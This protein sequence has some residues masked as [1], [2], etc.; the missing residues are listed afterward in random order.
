LAEE[1]RLEEDVD[2]AINLYEK[3][4][5]LYENLPYGITYQDDLF[6]ELA[7]SLQK[8]IDNQENLSDQ[9]SPKIL[10]EKVNYLMKA[11]NIN[12]ELQDY[13]RMLAINEKIWT[14]Y[15][16]ENND[17]F[18]QWMERFKL[19]VSLALK[20]GDILEIEE[21]FKSVV[22]DYDP[23]FSP[24]DE[25]GEDQKYAD[26]YNILPSSELSQFYQ[27]I[28]TFLNSKGLNE[29]K[30]K[31]QEGLKRYAKRMKDNKLLKN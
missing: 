15:S 19:S 25:L 26:V 2:K 11:Y 4:I 22:P 3:A 31:I 24:E 10:I 21:L 5:N 20:T 28:I 16:K 9:E 6:E 1:A 12:E 8:K 18:A 29:R 13:G 7:E 30:D 27:D 17:D 23:D 14:H